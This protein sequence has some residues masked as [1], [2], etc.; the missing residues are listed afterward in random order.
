MTL[1]DGGL[2]SPGH[3]QSVFTFG[4]SYKC[5]DS[6]SAQVAHDF[7]PKSSISLLP[8]ECPCFVSLLLLLSD[9]DSSEGGNKCSLH[10]DCQD[11][12]MA[13]QTKL[14]LSGGVFGSI[15]V[16]KITLSNFLDVYV[17]LIT[18]SAS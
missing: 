4:F 11:T 13:W 5:C 16:P 2:L 15:T 17:K 18:L 7:S 6:L 10:R 14:A 12:L 3:I 1:V 9:W 8:L